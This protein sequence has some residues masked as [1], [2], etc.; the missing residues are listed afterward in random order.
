MKLGFAVQN[1]KNQNSRRQ[2][3]QNKLFYATLAYLMESCTISCGYFSHRGCPIRPWWST[4]RV[5]QRFSGL[6][7]TQRSPPLQ[8]GGLFCPLLFRAAGQLLISFGV[9]FIFWQ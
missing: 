7:L 5:V 9:R 1:R 4:L 2:I 6:P 3:I 8:V